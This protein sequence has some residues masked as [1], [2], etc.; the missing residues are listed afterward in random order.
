MAKRRDGRNWDALRDEWVDRRL[1]G[2]NLTRQDFAAEKGIPYDTLRRHSTAWKGRLDQREAEVQALVQDRTTIDHATMRVAILE[3]RECLRG[4]FMQQAGVWLEWSAEEAKKPAAERLRMP[5]KD[6]V[7]LEN[8]M[9]RM[10]EVGAGLPKEHV[11]RHDEAHDPVSVGRREMAEL[12]NTVVE[13][14]RW[15]RERRKEAEAKEAKEVAKAKRA[16]KAKA[17]KE[18]A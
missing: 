13:L 9:V 3:E 7:A 18:E 2:E 8:L 5:I 16:K 10:A 4:L 14:A 1:R 6:L 17:D 12:E 11:V 15:K